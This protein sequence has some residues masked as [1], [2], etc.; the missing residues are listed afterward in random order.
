MIRFFDLCKILIEKEKVDKKIKQLELNK[1]IRN[2]RKK[3]ESKLS[4]KEIDH[5][6]IIV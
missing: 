6:K 3:K 4:K 5:A 1:K 2:E